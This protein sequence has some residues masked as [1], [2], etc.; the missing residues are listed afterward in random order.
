MGKQ[1]PVATTKYKGFGSFDAEGNYVSTEILY[2]TE[3]G[4]KRL[5]PSGPGAP[6]LGGDLTSLS[7]VPTG[8]YESRTRNIQMMGTTDL[9]RITRSETLFA[10][11]TGTPQYKPGD[12]V[13]IAIPWNQEK[14]RDIQMK[15]TRA[16]ALNPE[17]SSRRGVWGTGEIAAAEAVMGFANL[18]GWDFDRALDTLVLDGDARQQAGLDGSGGPG[19]SGSRGPLSVTDTSYSLSS[20]DQARQALAAVMATQIGRKPSDAEVRKFLGQLNAKERKAPI[21]TTTTQTPSGAF[22]TTLKKDR[23]IDPTEEATRFTQAQAPG[24]VQG[25]GEVQ[26]YDIL[27]SV[28]GGD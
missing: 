7:R 20:L 27:A 3:A 5:T 14:I 21:T 22:Q 28:I 11:Q 19:G 8:D 16:G 26:Y 23:S 25:Y 12:Q 13:S 4:D 9:G 1:A 17:M 24:E 18:R 6:D 10:A 2:G 15:M